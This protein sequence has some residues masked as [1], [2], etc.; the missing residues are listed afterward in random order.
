M[1]AGWTVLGLYNATT[2]AQANYVREAPPFL[3]RSMDVLVML[4]LIVVGGNAAALGWL[5]ALPTIGGALANLI[6]AI[7]YRLVRRRRLRG[8][9][10]E[11]LNQLERMLVVRPLRRVDSGR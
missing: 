1:L 4:A 6:F 10:D 7:L 11:A 8:F 3:T 9:V 2:G 5:S